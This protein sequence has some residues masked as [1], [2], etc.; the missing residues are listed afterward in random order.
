M[1]ASV[2]EARDYMFRM[3][4]AVTTSGILIR[5]PYDGKENHRKFAREVGYALND[6]DEAGQREIMC[7]SYS[8][9][10]VTGCNLKPLLDAKEWNSLIRSQ[11]KEA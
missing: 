1:K 8:T 10:Y 9:V 3:R 11:I 7:G 2:E 4:S 6:F 5:G